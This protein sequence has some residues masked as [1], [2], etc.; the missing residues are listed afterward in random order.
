MHPK[1]LAKYGIADPRV[2]P[3]L[4]KYGVTH[5]DVEKTRK[6]FW[7]HASTPFSKMATGKSLVERMNYPLKRKFDEDIKKAGADWYL[8]AQK[9]YDK[10]PLPQGAKDFLTSYS[11]RAKM[12]AVGLPHATREAVANFADLTPIDVGLMLATAG[13]AKVPVKGVPLGHLAKTV[14]VGKGFKEGVR[15][16]QTLAKMARVPG[17]VLT[18][19]ADDALRVTA[20]KAKPLISI[21][22]VKVSDG[23]KH[24]KINLEKYEPEVASAI[25]KLI[26]NDPGLVKR[27]VINHKQ[28]STMADNL[29]DDT[30]RRAILSKPE[31]ELAASMLRLRRGEDAIIRSVMG[32]DL[33]DLGKGLVQVLQR[34]QTSAVGRMGSEIG[35]ALESMK[36]SVDA[37]DDMAKMIVSKI[38][39]VRSS[40]SVVGPEKQ[41]LVDGLIQL[42]KTVLDPDFNPTWFDKGYEYWI[43]TILSGPWTHTV[44]VTSN[45]M[46]TAMKPFEKAVF[47]AHDAVLSAF[48][49]RK[50][51]H[52]FREVPAQVRG[53]WASRA[54]AKNKLPT[55]VAPGTKL[56]VVRRPLIRGKHG[57]LIRTPTK[58]LVVEDNFAKRLVGFMELH[59]RAT[60]T[61]LQEG[62][63]GKALNSRINQLIGNPTE[64]LTGEVLREQ[65]YR[66]FQDSTGL[67]EILMGMP[68]KGV[69]WIL[70][71]RKTLAS[72]LTKGTEYT[73]L[74]YGKAAARGLGHL[75][76]RAYPQYEAAQDL[77]KAAMGTA[78]FGGLV[79]GYMKGRITGS[80]PRDAGKREAWYKSG[81]APYTF[82]P[83][84]PPEEGGT[85]VPFDRLEPV[86]TAMMMMVDF[87]QGWDDASKKEF[88]DMS[89]SEKLKEAIFKLTHGLQS[90]T[91]LSGMTNAVNAVVE[92]E[93]YA[94]AFVGRMA[95]GFVPGAGLLR[96]IQR[97]GDPYVRDPRSAETFTQGVFESL[98]KDIPGLAHNVPIKIDMFGEEVKRHA[99][100]PSHLTPYP[101]TQ[102]KMDLVYDELVRLGVSVGHPS[103]KITI[104]GFETK[105]KREDYRQ[106][107]KDIGPGLYAHI[108]NLLSDPRYHMLRSNV[109]KKHVIK[110]VVDL[111]RRLGRRKLTQE[112]MRKGLIDPQTIR[113]YWLGNTQESIRTAPVGQAVGDLI[114]RHNLGITEEDRLRSLSR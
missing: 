14:R 60:A 92:P 10:L 104:R 94:E 87:I 34:R 13:L 23:K 48:T 61:A 30:I 110:R 15:Y 81:K 58:L 1:L 8:E 86:G 59:G 109:I 74:S 51:T 71:F 31:G 17:K 80:P 90:K 38:K 112:Y 42:R 29:K 79:Y 91:F 20:A 98:M 36:M 72:I 102:G 9:T 103:K 64:N 108:H 44:N 88:E 96:N 97:V 99:L 4:Q 55:G 45:T 83:G 35:R 68:Q 113:D 73:P 52:F 47:A 18:N 95:G 100:P 85:G 84:K 16:Q 2:K 63:K 57:E 65:L 82:Y 7:G 28:L 3:V 101:I 22:D 50:R 5:E 39:Q 89:G 27:K 70:P 69:R 66:T 93:R 62:L 54:W 24:S 40:K 106:M 67:G 32:G 75:A 6:N 78:M 114:M 37:Q 77:G 19:A 107:L 53:A 41:R 33:D 111:H 46:F 26:T 43:N 76:G 25:K 11:V 56:D 105:I 21:D 49:G 12:F